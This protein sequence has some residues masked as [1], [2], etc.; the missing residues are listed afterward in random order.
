MSSGK[1]GTSLGTLKEEVRPG[2][3][4]SYANKG[5]GT[6]V[7]AKGN[8]ERGG[9]MLIRE[10]CLPRAAPR[11]Q[12]WR[13]VW[14]RDYANKSFRTFGRQVEKVFREGLRK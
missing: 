8:S 11:A 13:A 10:L 5:R 3:R 7:S 12:A 6:T 9:D 1:E 4:R 14:G 2:K